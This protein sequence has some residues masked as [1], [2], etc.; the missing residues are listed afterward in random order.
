MTRSSSPTRRRRPRWPSSAT[1][2]RMRSRT[3]GERPGS[4]S[5]GSEQVDAR[6][7]RDPQRHA[8]VA[9]VAREQQDERGDHADPDGDEP[10]DA[11]ELG[12]ERLLSRTAMTAALTPELALAYIRELSADYLGGAVLDTHLER[13]AG[14]AA[15]A[16]DVHGEGATA[17]G[18]VF[19]ARTATH[20]IVVVT[21]ARALP[22]PT[23]R[24][25]H[26]VLRALSGETAQGTPREPL[27]TALVNALVSAVS[28]S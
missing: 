1:S 3:A 22:G 19:A 26:T 8:G 13:L 25:I 6:G 10:H 7:D 15:L 2:T 21:T 17:H 14:D 18:R 12:H 5:H 16:V 28:A 20:A 11:L 23:R 24:D 4:S 9:V 27:E